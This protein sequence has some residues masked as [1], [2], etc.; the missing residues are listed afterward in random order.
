MQKVKKFVR[1]NWIILASITVYLVIFCTSIY[2]YYQRLGAFGCFDDCFNYMGGYFLL[3][4]KQIYSEFFFNHAPFM[5]YISFI[6][7]KIT[8]P[9]DTY[10]LILFHKLFLFGFSFLMGIFLILRFR[11][12]ALGF[13]IIYE[14]TKFFVFG[15]RFLSESFIVYPAVYMFGVVLLKGS[16][17]RLKYYDYIFCGIFT[18][19]I[20]FMREPYA[21]L[22]I[23]LYLLILTG[24]NALKPK[25]FSLLF[26]IG[27]SAF[28][29][30]SIPINEYIQNVFV[31]NQNRITQEASAKGGSIDSLLLSFFYPLYLMFSGEKTIFRTVLI[32]IG[33]VFFI[34]LTKLAKIKGIRLPILVLVILGLSN[35]R[36]ESPGFMYF[37]SFH[38]AVWYALFIFS[39]LFMIKTISRNSKELFALILPVFLIAVYSFIS[40]DSLMKSKTDRITEFNNG[41]ANE[42]VYG[43]AIK[44]LSNRD[45]TLFLE[46]TDDLIY[47]VADLNTSYKYGWYTSFMPYIDKYSFERAAMFEN[48]FPDFYYDA[49]KLL[50]QNNLRPSAKEINRQYLRLSVNSKPSCLLIK[51]DKIKA[52]SDKSWN[53]VKPLGFTPPQALDKLF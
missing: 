37:Q 4:G 24:R 27:L 52:I 33:L 51:K 6:I 23:L 19:F 35:I 9:Q 1:R 11:L 2:F 25:I 3:K 44:S 45:D 53:S 13:L 5:P 39:C 32:I 15:D 28:T 50:K 40:S 20:I 41:Y 18:W 43:T 22:S 26:F 38:M 7:Q 21:P 47:W 46:G 31:Y 49:C 42:F 30:F 17:I 16:N 12:I 48:N 10:S 29:L 34:S 14:T 36:A 8:Q